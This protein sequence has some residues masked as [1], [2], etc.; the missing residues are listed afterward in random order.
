MV[1]DP[2]TS[3]DPAVGKAL[4]PGGEL[5]MLVGN[6]MLS[7]QGVEHMVCELYLCFF[8][9]S[10]Q[11]AAAVTYYAVRTF[12]ARC[13]VVDALVGFFCTEDQKS[14]WHKVL[15]SIRKRS[16][17]RNSLAHGVFITHKQGDDLQPM[18]SRNPLDIASFPTGDVKRTQFI[19]AKEIRDML[20][21]FHKVMT[22]TEALKNDLVDSP[23]LRAAR[24]Q[25]PSRLQVNRRRSRLQSQTPEEP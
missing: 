9:R 23:E 24:L 8:E 13:G 11:E 21:C 14:R 22:E 25:R 4:D 10:A 17:S 3:T 12:D 18:I 5:M 1:K 20:G 2:T 16:R 15:Q 19:S 7:W 6:A